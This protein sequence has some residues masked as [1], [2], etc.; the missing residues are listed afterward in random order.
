MFCFAFKQVQKLVWKCVGVFICFGLVP[1]QKVSSFVGQGVL[2]PPLLRLYLETST[3]KRILEK[4]G[5]LLTFENIVS[6]RWCL[7]GNWRYCFF[8]LFDS[9]LK[10]ILAASPILIFF[11]LLW[12]N[13][14][15]QRNWREKRFVWLTLPGYGVIALRRVTV[16]PSH[17][18]S[19]TK[20]RGQ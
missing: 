13:P 15:Y 8:F 20:S 3:T 9:V 19:T 11:L 12:Q 4:L 14:P 1:F 2:L 10:C 17:M 18:T 6:S 7:T 5:C 16:V